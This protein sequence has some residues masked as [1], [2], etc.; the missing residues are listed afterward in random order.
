VLVDV[1]PD[2]EPRRVRRFLADRGVLDVHG[3]LVEDVLI[4]VPRLRRITEEL[5]LPVL[6]V[7]G[8]SGSAVTDGDVDRFLRL[9]PHATVARVRGAG[10]LV[11]RDRPA[12]L[13]EAIA[14]T[15]E[16]PALALLRDLGAGEVDHPGGNLLDHLQRVR[17][18]VA[19]WDGGRRLSLAALCHAAYGTDGFPHALLPLEQ[20]ARLRQAIGDEAESLVYLYDACDR[21]ETY[22]RLGAAP[23][24]LTDR[25]TGEAVPLADA[26]LTGF[27]LLTI[28][29]ELDVAR[30]APLTSEVRRGIRALITAMAAYVPDAS[31][32]ALADPFLR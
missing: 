16:W 18:L 4:R 21:K 15:A 22:A 1:V 5:D 31:A 9:A 24:P 29:N 12:A 7:R 26:D 2:L 27:A 14:A 6:L 10:H 20:R 13:A 25:F 11:A 23:L 30:H 3:D 17:E 32:R 28:A 19:G 8:G